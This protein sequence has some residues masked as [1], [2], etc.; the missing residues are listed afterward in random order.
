ML[1][2]V[3]IQCRTTQN[4]ITH[5]IA[6]VGGEVTKVVLI[7]PVLDSQWSVQL[8]KSLRDRATKETAWTLILEQIGDPRSQGR[9]GE[10]VRD[11]C[12]VCFEVVLV[13]YQG[14]ERAEFHWLS[15]APDAIQRP[16]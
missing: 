6:F 4:E 7:G 14:I 13:S 2:Q 15:V 1:Q 16:G 9:Y 5:Y 10:T 8:W 3:I 11:G 12:F